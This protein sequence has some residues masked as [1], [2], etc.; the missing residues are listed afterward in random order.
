[1]K[2]SK[3]LTIQFFF[4]IAMASCGGGDSDLQEECSQENWTGTYMGTEQCDEETPDFMII[5]RIVEAGETNEELLY[6]GITYDILDCVAEA[7]GFDTERNAN[8]VSTLELLPGDS[9]KIT[10]T[11]DIIGGISCRYFGQK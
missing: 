2:L 6:N 7:E 4:L 11:Y 8:W 1:M 10:F 5:S 3:L 9:I